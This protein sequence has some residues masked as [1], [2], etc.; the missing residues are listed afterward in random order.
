MGED[1]TLTRLL[2]SAF[3]GCSRSFVL[4]CAS[5]D[6][7]DGDATLNA[8][9]FAERCA[10]VTNQVGLAAMSVD[11]AMAAIRAALNRSRAAMDAAPAGSEARARLAARFEMLHRRESELA[12]TKGFV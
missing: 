10:L 9:R 2:R 12:E 1:G 5:P 3:G 11:E 6:A 4:T 8:L 7:R